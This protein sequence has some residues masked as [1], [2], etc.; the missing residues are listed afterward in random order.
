M[1]SDQQRKQEAVLKF[2]AARGG[3]VIRKK[4]LTSRVLDGG[5][6]E[7]DNVIETLLEQ[8]RIFFNQNGN[9]KNSEYILSV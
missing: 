3:R 4:L 7:Y 1:A 2:I 6:K 9:K 8:D 5:A